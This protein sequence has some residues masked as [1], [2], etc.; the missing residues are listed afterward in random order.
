MAEP[1]EGNCRDQRLELIFVPWQQVRKRE[2]WEKLR[3]GI[4]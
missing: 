3:G 4:R 2:P 1:D